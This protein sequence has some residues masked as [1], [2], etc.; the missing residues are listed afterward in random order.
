M[1][2]SN[3][4]KRTL[5]STAIITAG[6]NASISHA[7]SEGL[8]EILVTTQFVEQNLQETPVAVTGITSEGL[9]ARGYQTIDNIS[10][11]SPNVTLTQG[12]GYSGPSL[13]GFI[14]GVGQTDFNPA[15]EAGVGLYVD[16]VY[17]SQLSGSILE[18]LDLE[19]VEVLRG[20]QGTL[21]GKNS[22]GGAI[23]LYTQRPDEEANGYLEAGFG[24]LNAVLVRG[25]SNLTLVKDK[26]YA[27]FSGVSRTVDG[28]VDRLDYNCANPNDP[29]DG[30]P[31]FVNVPD[32]KWGEDGGSS[33]TGGRIAL[34]W[35]ANDDLEINLST[36]KV[37]NIMG[38]PPSV[39]IGVDDVTVPPAAAAYGYNW[40]EV[41]DRFL[42]PDGEY[43]TYGTY[44]NPNNN[45]NIQD[46]MKVQTEGTTLNIDWNITDTL[47]LQ[48]ITGYRE[49]ETTFGTD[50][51]QSP[52][53]LVQQYQI[54]THEQTSQEF[55]LNGEVADWLDYTVGAFYFD[56]HTELSAR[57]NLGYVGFDFLHGPDP[58]DTENTAV[59]ANAIFS[60]MDSVDITLGI[61]QS[62]DEKVYTYRRRNPDFSA[63]EECLGPPGTPGNPPNCLISAVEGTSSTY[64]DSRTD[65]RAAVSWLFSDS[66]MAYYQYSTGFKG[67]GVNPRPFYAEQA[68]TFNPEEL[69]THEIGLKTQLLDDRMR[70]NMAYFQND[71][72]DVQLTLIDCSGFLP[73]ELATPCLAPQN[74]GDAESSGFEIELDY[75]P[76]E[77]WIIEASASTLDFEYT[78]L[79]PT[80]GLTGNEVT[81]FTPELT[82]SLSTQVDF[83]TS[84]GTISPRIDANYQD[85]V[86]SAASITD[87]GNIE[88]YT[89]VN[90]SVTWLSMDE[91][92][93]ARFDVRNL[94]DEYYFL[95]KTDSAGSG[96]GHAYGLLGAPRTWTLSVKYMF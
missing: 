73:T 68:V 13:V 42:V 94:T 1:V 86:Q 64:D 31:S 51:D 48:S 72:T 20:P 77:I 50:L 59:F 24:D 79:S 29:I 91:A 44:V 92:W 57:V 95:N 6:M 39:L 4:L 10:A 53:P 25:A 3:Q 74:A 11:Q 32:C 46:E 19:R 26:L 47:Q 75:K 96:A 22:I 14:R 23:K 36:E 43:Y 61:R 83:Y 21:A 55:R 9:V 35:L 88:D 78:T 65:V 52:W 56:S 69:E 28:Y 70:I 54:L 37:N 8:E 15:L 81:P 18:L 87:Y 90:A 89:L 76:T 66:S 40:A 5:L 30:L 38:A 85:E 67:G 93:Q 62:N 58:V 49:F 60:P 41:M 82:W 63:I 45:L 12:G 2:K 16:D 80:A 27:R 17:Y 33:Y 34:R 7:K 84:A 71:Y